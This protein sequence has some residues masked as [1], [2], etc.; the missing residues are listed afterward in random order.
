M[1]CT[2]GRRTAASEYETCNWGKISSHVVMSSAVR[3]AGIRGDYKL[4]LKLLSWDFGAAGAN[5]DLF[6]LFES[7]KYGKQNLMFTDET[8]QLKDVASVAGGTRTNYYTWAG[9]C[10][11]NCFCVV[12]LVKLSAYLC[13]TWIGKSLIRNCFLCYYKSSEVKVSLCVWLSTRLVTWSA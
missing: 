9:K 5:T 4:L 3:D 1:I 2:D 13:C 7:S 10:F 11:V 8:Q 12:A 6:Q